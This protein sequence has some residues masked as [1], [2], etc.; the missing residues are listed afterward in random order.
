MS[1]TRRPRPKPKAP[2]ETKLEPFLIR[3]ELIGARM[4]EHGEPVSLE[5]MGTVEILKANFGRVN[6]LVNQAIEQARKQENDPT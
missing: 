1:N 2:K 5:P 3:G 6:Q 4:N